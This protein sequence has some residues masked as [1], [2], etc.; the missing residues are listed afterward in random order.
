MVTKMGERYTL[1]SYIPGR[2]QSSLRTIADVRSIDI[3]Q[4]RELARA[5]QINAVPTFIK[6][7]PRNQK[8]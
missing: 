8:A 2:R 6:E 5:D 3:R 4:R 7:A 1:Q